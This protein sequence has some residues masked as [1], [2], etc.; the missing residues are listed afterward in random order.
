MGSVVTPAVITG[1]AS[2]VLSVLALWYISY[3]PLKV[4]R[5]SLGVGIE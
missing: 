3:A 5:T 1:I 4:C 2:D